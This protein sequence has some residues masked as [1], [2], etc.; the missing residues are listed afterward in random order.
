MLAITSGVSRVDEEQ[1]K[2]QAL[3]FRSA[4]GG[5]LWSLI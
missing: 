1:L 2:Q 5:F 4:Y 3:K